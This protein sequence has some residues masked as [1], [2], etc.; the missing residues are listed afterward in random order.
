MKD[1]VTNYFKGRTSWWWISNTIFWLLIAG[2]VFPST[3][4]Y[5]RQAITWVFISNPGN[6]LSEE[7]EVP[8][9]KLVNLNGHI[10]DAIPSEKPIFI[11][12]WATWCGSCVSEMPSLQK[13][14]DNYKEQI[15][16]YFITQSDTPPKVAAF[17]QKHNYRL[18]MHF[19]SREDSNNAIYQLS[20]S[21]PTSYI[22]KNGKI[23]WKHTGIANYASDAFYETVEEFIAN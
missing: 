9:L 8:Y 20:N 11:N 12:M 14:Y 7:I 16:F 17:L 1:I 5:M 23:I 2:F 4:N 3:R 15:D 19:I 6:K 18:P 21:I 22:I 13:F 10:K